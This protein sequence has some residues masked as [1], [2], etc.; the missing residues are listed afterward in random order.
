ML[1]LALACH[2][3]TTLDAP[4]VP[5]AYDYESPPDAVGDPLTPEEVG[6]GLQTAID[7]TARIHPGLLHEAWAETMEEHADPDCPAIE[8][9]NGQDHWR[10]EPCTSSDGTVF[11]GWSLFYRDIPDLDPEVIEDRQ[12][13]EVGWLS[14]Q[15]TITEPDGVVLNSYGDALYEH[16]QARDGS[17]GRTGFVWGDFRWTDP[18][19]VDTWLQDGLT[20]EMYYS[21]IDHGN[22]NA[23]EMD[24]SMAFLPEPVPAT[25][26]EGLSLVNEPGSCALEP[27]AYIRV[28]DTDGRWYEVEF[29]GSTARDGDCD[30]C[31]AVWLDD[32]EIGKAC[33]DWAPLLSVYEEP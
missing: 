14:G 3:P 22:F 18:R 5:S 15:A 7:F 21:Y 30:G 17:V 31:G 1:L 19:A 11:R 12:Y 13:V 25:I 28:R 2:S 20:M 26:W 6:E 33:V 23:T 16:W 32:R 9:H 24:L 10:E 27:G 8:P 29:D 4:V